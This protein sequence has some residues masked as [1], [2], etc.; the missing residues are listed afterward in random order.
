[1]CLSQGLLI[2]SSEAGR[3][4]ITTGGA[5]QSTS[6]LLQLRDSNEVKDM[7][8]ACFI[9]YSLMPSN[10]SQGFQRSRCSGLPVLVLCWELNLD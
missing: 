9:E 8:K 4:T 5:A 6:I 10:E 2:R 7:P 3:L 1:M